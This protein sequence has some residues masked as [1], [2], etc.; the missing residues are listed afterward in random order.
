MAPNVND[1]NV[2][3]LRQPFIRLP[4]RIY[5]HK[6]MA[7]HLLRDLAANTTSEPSRFLLLRMAGQEH[8]HM[9]QEAEILRKLGSSVPPER[10]SWFSRDWRWLLVVYRTKAA[11]TWFK[12]VK[13]RLVAE[14]LALRKEMKA[15]HLIYEDNEV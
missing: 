12:W 7:E 3:R 13:R 4:Q 14:E 8:R 10:E 9:I 1:Q 6:Q 15:N 5:C 11:L 2:R